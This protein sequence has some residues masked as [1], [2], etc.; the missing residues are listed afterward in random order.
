MRGRAQGRDAPHQRLR[1]WMLV[2]DVRCLFP[3]EDFPFHCKLPRVYSCSLALLP[4]ATDRAPKLQPEITFMNMPQ[5]AQTRREFLSE[6]GRGMV[7]AAVGY[8]L[9]SE[10]GLSSAI[11]EE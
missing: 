8:G 7:T 4:L 11:G 10:L 5:S 6:V 9:A 1:Y 3:G 2:W